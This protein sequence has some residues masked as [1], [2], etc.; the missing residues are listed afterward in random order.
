MKRKL[1]EE[2]PDRLQAIREWANLPI[3]PGTLLANPCSPLYWGLEKGEY[4]TADFPEDRSLAYLIGV[5]GCGNT[6]MMYENLVRNG[7]LCVTL[8]SLDD[9]GIHQVMTA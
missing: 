6:R 8:Q 4:L 3:T 5:S 1:R 2:D 9:G 7:G